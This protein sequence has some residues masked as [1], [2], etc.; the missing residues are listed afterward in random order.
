MAYGRGFN[1]PRLHHLPIS[2]GLKQYQ[3]IPK[4]P[5]RSTTWA[6]LLGGFASFDLI[7]FRCFHDPEG[8]TFGVAVH[9]PASTSK[10]GSMA[11]HLI[12]S[13]TTIRSI[14]PGD[15][16]RRPTGCRR[17]RK[18]TSTANSWPRASTRMLD[19]AMPKAQPK[20]A[21]VE[22]Q[23][24]ERDAISDIAI[25]ARRLSVEGFICDSSQ[26]GRPPRSRSSRPAA[27]G[28]TATFAP[29]ARPHDGRSRFATAVRSMPTTS[30]AASA[31]EVQEQAPVAVSISSRPPASIVKT[32]AN[33]CLLR[34][35]AP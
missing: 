16:R 5:G 2:A 8:V 33:M 29:T 19:Q 30:E 10:S 18:P 24:A 13:D 27:S 3:R 25:K 11:R 23:S 4:S 12:P 31:S 34:R 6:F 7:R 17:A 32:R 1:S 35:T 26:N 20:T 22:L 9:P 28:Q 14:E 15:E 21:A